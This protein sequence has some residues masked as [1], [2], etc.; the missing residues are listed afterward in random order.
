MTQS[1][2]TGQDFNK[3]SKLFGASNNTIVDFSDLNRC[4][5]SF[6]SLQGGFGEFAI[7]S[8][9]DH[10]AVF[11]DF[12]HGFCFFLDR[13][14][15]LSARTDQHTDLFWVDL[16]CQQAWSVWRK[17][18]RRTWNRGQHLAQDLDTSF[19]RLS[20]R[21]TDHIAANAAN[22]KVQLNSGD[23]VLSTSDFEVH[24]SE[25]IFRAKNIGQ[26]N[27][28]VAFLDHAHRNTGNGVFDFDTCRHQ[29]QRR[30]TNSRHGRRAVRFE[31]V[32]DNTN[33]VREIIDIGKNGFDTAFCQSTVTDLT[34]ARA[35]NR[36]ALAN[37][38]AGEV[39]IQHELFGVLVLQSID[40]L[41]VASGTQSDRN[42]GLSFAALEHSGTV[43]AW[44]DIDQAF[45]V[46]QVLRSTTVGTCSCQDRFANDRRF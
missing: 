9:N 16:G 17:R 6:D 36:T 32:R 39:V 11:G 1:V 25:V 27:V 21:L 33:G 24:V 7:A 13:T 40:S 38:E 42:H 41:L 37:T 18:L 23:T 12:D 2:A 20:Q 14:D 15:V 44:H 19:L 31:D 26:Q 28:L 30:S 4:G 46:S 43:N 8:R 29:R 3:G 35:T 34:T 10:L 5:T 45:D 22:L